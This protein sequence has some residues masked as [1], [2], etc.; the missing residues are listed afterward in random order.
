MSAHVLKRV[1]LLIV[2]ITF[3]NTAVSANNE[4]PIKRGLI[5]A[6]EGE[7]YVLRGTGPLPAIEGFVLEASDSVLVKMGG[8]CSGFT[9][10]GEHFEI[11]GPGRITFS[12]EQT[13]VHRNRIA[14]W[15]SQQVAHWIGES[16]NYS[17]VSRSVRD[18]KQIT[19]PIRL[20][21]PAPE[22]RVR[23]SRAQFY[24]TT[25]PA[26]DRYE[27]IITPQN[28]KEN[29]QLIRGFKAIKT[30]LTPGTTY[31]WTVMPK[32]DEVYV[33]PGERSFRVMT[34]EEE[35]TLEDS[36]RDLPN[37][38]AGVL[39]LS[40]GLH[41]EA[42]YRFDAAVSSGINRQSALRWRARAFAII[43]MYNEAYRD[44]NET[45]N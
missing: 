4:P 12:G 34:L 37:L 39:L 17:L 40:A 18:W 36:L 35:R 44:L 3:H 8:K 6:A 33:I 32:A 41:D 43:E 27:L 10:G 15:I 29:Q 31:Y 11:N 21:I 22:G 7:A 45:I 42:I 38:E 30:D 14:V 23:A 5:V 19:E 28:G 1:I 2:I 26:V 16:R 9:P 25:I 24:W 20:I 13:D